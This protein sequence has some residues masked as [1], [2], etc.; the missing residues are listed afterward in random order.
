MPI[1]IIVPQLGESVV[2]GTISKWLKN[3][4]DSV[5]EEEPLVEIMTDKIT[6]EVPSPGT[7]TLAQILVDSG[8]IPIGEK[9]A[10]LLKPG[11]TEADLPKAGTAAGQAAQSAGGAPKPPTSGT[12]TAVAETS[13]EQ[14]KSAAAPQ[15]AEG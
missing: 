13:Q 6:I 1:T 2:E 8:T 7:G 14:P 3:V 11:E 9:I 10:Y 12:A 5:K 15:T 4:G